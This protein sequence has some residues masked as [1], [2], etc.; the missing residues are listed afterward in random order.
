MS[1]RRDRINRNYEQL[2]DDIAKD[3]NKLNRLR[4]TKRDMLDPYRE[5]EY[6]SANE[7]EEDQD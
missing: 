4:V 2:D 1:R 7:P 3:D 5:Q 6:S